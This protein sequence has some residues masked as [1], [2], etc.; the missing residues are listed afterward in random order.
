MRLF[1]NW[2]IKKLLLGDATSGVVIEGIM[3]YKKKNQIPLE[4][5]IYF[6]AIKVPHHGSDVNLS[7]EL[8]KHID[9]PN[10]IFCGCTSSAPHLH[11][12]ANIIYQPLL[13]AI[14]KRKLCF[15]SFYYKND[16][17][18]KMKTKVPVLVKEGIEIEV[19]QIN[20]IAL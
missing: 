13:D 14:Q 19:L 4:T 18:N 12:L 2:E 5:K 15:N 6:D 7:K 20:E 10:W 17:Y 1:G 3:A 8:L 16:I 11:T 9:N